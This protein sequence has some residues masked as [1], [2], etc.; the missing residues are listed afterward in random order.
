MNA[1][2]ERGALFLT[3][4]VA[5]GDDAA[6]TTASSTTDTADTTAQP[7][8]NGASSAAEGTSSETGTAASSSAS[9]TTGSPGMLDVTLSFA[10]RVGS[11]TAA[12][13]QSYDNVGLSNATV[14]LRDIRFYVSNIRLVDIDSNEMPLTL[15]QDGAW[16]HENVVLLDFEDGTGECSEGTTSET[17]TS[18]VGTVPM[19][20]YTGIRFDV[21]VPFELNH[22]DPA[23]A[24][25]PLNDAAMFW[26]WASGYKF[27]KI[28]FT[29]ENA[30]PDNGWFV[31]LG[32]QDCTS[33]APT[34]APTE[35]CSRPA[36]PAIALE[37][38]DAAT[39]TIVLDL[40]AL[41]I[42]EDVN[43]DTEESSPGCMS[44]AADAAECDALFPALGL[45]WDTGDCTD[46][47]S[48]QTVFS[49]E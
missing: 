4:A 21:G 46:S 12:C 16:Q 42:G 35:A 29:N 3:L 28:E 8:T 41:V 27:M 33:K 32:S 20:T 15:V 17:N 30:E 36:R 19:G 48:A 11:E 23:T 24:P 14:T 7:G 49:V 47:C 31:H 26:V 18:V 25:A 1:L 6:T 39:N 37:N 22:V 44:F 40:A 5:C 38:F 9:S 34:E 2:A 10:A 13:G 45:S 43:A